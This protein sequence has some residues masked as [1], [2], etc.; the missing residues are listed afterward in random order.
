MAI[1]IKMKSSLINSMHFNAYVVLLPCPVYLM[2]K[3]LGA[4][5]SVTV[6]CCSVGGAAFRWVLARYGGI[7]G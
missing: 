2:A 6:N 4:S 5:P 1:D 3:F 7:T